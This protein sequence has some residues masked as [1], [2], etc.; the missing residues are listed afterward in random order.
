[1]L[2]YQ[3]HVKYNLPHI[4]DKDLWLWIIPAINP[5]PICA[6]KIGPEQSKSG[7]ELLES[8]KEVGNWYFMKDSQV[9]HRIPSYE[10]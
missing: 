7:G 5:C 2:L 10:K 9:C 4:S 6:V 1:M 8:W 3:I